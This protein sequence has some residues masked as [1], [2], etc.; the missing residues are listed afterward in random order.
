MTPTDSRAAESVLP[1]K[2]ADF[3]ILMVLT[4]GAR[5][6]YGM[7]QR[8]A[9]QSSGR[10]QL[11]VGSLYRLIARMTEGGLIVECKTPRGGS[12]RRRYYRISEL[13]TR[14]VAAEAARLNKLAQA[15]RA[16]KLIPRSEGAR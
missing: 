1:L 5:H 10:V 8:V 16:K 2:P 15:A 9:E 4:E 11:E 7:M 14:V 3:H 12:E 13:G 6:G